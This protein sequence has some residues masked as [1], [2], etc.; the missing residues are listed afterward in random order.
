MSIANAI[1]SS[2]PTAAPIWLERNRHL[3]VALT[4]FLLII[5]NL[6]YFRYGTVTR[7]DVCYINREVEKPAPTFIPIRDGLLHDSSV[8]VMWVAMF[9]LCLLPKQR[10]L[11]FF[12]LVYA[13]IWF[14]STYILL[15]ALKSLLMDYNC[16][17]RHK[18]YPNGISGHYCY[19]I[20]V[21]LTAYRLGHARLSAH[22][23]VLKPLARLVQLLLSLFLIGAVSTLYR[24]YYH[25]YHSPRQIG[26]GS[27]LGISSFVGLDY[28]LFPSHEQN[29]VQ[30]TV[31]T[32]LSTSLTSLALYFRWWPHGEA[33]PAISKGQ[34]IFHAIL[35][36]LLFVTIFL[37]RRPEEKES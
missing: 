21:S 27:A 20:F 30:L 35:W 28:V 4:V 37:R 5:P 14:H 2:S 33:G 29:S 32:L 31:S 19:F 11:A 24:T 17:G 25:G 1:P 13:S 12:R 8:F 15:A 18:L 36:L 6:T 23:N 26:L 9:T 3:L 34:L 10:A 22:P 7:A 16:A